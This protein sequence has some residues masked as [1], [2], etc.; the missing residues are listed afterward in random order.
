VAETAPA[1][2]TDEAT[3]GEEMIMSDE[4]GNTGHGPTGTTVTDR[5]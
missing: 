4:R 5:S 2:R 1:A 3:T